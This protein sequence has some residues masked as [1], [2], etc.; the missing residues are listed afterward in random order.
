MY[1]RKFIRKLGQYAVV[2]GSTVMMPHWLQAESLLSE[3]AKLQKLTILHTNDVHSRIDPFPMDGGSN[4]GQAGIARRSA[5]LKKI[6]SEEKNV[7]LLDA[8][9]MFQG[10]PYFNY[11][12][13]EL[14]IKL[15]SQLGYDAGTIGN[16][17]FDAGIENLQMQLKE[18]ADFPVINCNY[19]F[20]N[21]VMK[22]MSLPFKV[23]QKGSIK[24]G[25]TGVGVELDGLVPTPL[26][27][28][29]QY[30]HPIALADKNAAILRHDYKCDYVICLSHLGYSYKN[31]KVSDLV[32]AKETNH[33]DLIIG[34]HTHTFLNTPTIVANKAGRE[35]LVTQVGWAGIVLGRLDVYFERNRQQKCVLCKNTFVE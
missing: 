13:G 24:I 2:A 12:K 19:N 23:I 4:Q 30:S 10:T 32:M 27:K 20:D 34:G 5:L 8:G 14:E 25:I 33:I 1:R 17:D 11:F 26:I 29:T 21:T 3:E 16:H 18:Y 35:V 31:N 28:E 9:D 7:L 15:M 6:R 22:A